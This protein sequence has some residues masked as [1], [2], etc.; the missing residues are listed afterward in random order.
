MR[1]KAKTNKFGNKWTNGYQSGSES[2]RAQELKLLQHAGQIRELKEQVRYP[3]KVAGELI[4]SYQPDFV[5][6]DRAGQTIAEDVKGCK[7]RVYEIKK[8]LFM[9]LYPEI[10]FKEVPAC[11]GRRR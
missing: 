6:I 8:K 10:V 4:C 5:Y 3:L 1:W 11:R 2:D 9:A 7:T